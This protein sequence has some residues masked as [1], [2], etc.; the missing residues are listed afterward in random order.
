MRLSPMPLCVAVH[1]EYITL[2]YFIIRFLL[3]GLLAMLATEELFSD[4]SR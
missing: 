1:T 2:L 3:V 4:L